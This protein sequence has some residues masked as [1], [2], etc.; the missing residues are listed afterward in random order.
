VVMVE[1]FFEEGVGGD[2]D[3]DGK[4]RIALF[5]EKKLGRRE[6]TCLQSERRRHM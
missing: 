5:Q 2:S 3:F 1:S 6:A 4:S